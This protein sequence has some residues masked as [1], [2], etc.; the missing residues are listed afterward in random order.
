MAVGDVS[1][2]RVNSG[3]TWL[4]SI[5]YNE[6]DNPISDDIVIAPE[7]TYQVAQQIPPGATYNDWTPVTYYD[8]AT[9]TA[10]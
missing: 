2:G 8:I 4:V 6:V 5:D 1:F 9:R 7:I 3:A 10:V